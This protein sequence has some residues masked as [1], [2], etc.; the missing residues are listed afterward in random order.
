MHFSNFS[1]TFVFGSFEKKIF[2]LKNFKVKQIIKKNLC[3][4]LKYFRVKKM[5]FHFNFQFHALKIHT[6]KFQQTK[7]A[8]SRLRIAQCF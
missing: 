6:Y 4:F 3:E 2:G 5:Q 8:Y 7:L 1:I